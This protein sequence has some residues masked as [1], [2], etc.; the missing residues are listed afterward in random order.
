MKNL[1]Y[2]FEYHHNGFL[3]ARE[4]FKNNT[5]YMYEYFGLSG[6][7]EIKQTYKNEEVIIKVYKNDKLIQYTKKNKLYTYEIRFF[8]DYP[9]IITINNKNVEYSLIINEED[10]SVN[11]ESIIINN[12]RVHFYNKGFKD[13]FE[14]TKDPRYYE[15]NNQ[16]IVSNLEKLHRND[17]DFIISNFNFIKNYIN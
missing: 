10:L 8:S 5:L 11:Q 14:Q 7:R 15:Y 17:I 16:P 1:S 2:K 3:K 9:S 12:N 4:T 6:K 13:T